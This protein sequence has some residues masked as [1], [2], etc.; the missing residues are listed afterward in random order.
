MGQKIID[1]KPHRKGCRLWTA[2]DSLEVGWQRWTYQWTY[3]AACFC[4][5]FSLSYVLMHWGFVETSNTN[6]RLMNPANRNKSSEMSS[7]NSKWI[8]HEPIFAR[9]LT[10]ALPVFESSKFH[11]NHFHLWQKHVFSEPFFR[12]LISRGI[13]SSSSFKMST[14]HQLK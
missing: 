5:S 10:S 1:W 3:P 4:F 2:A 6:R 13:Q 11:R 8:N 9:V 12:T 7:G 14:N